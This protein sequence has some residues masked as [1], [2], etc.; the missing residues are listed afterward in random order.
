MARVRAPSSACSSRSST[1]SSTATA[2]CSTSATTGA[3]GSPTRRPSARTTRL[4]AIDAD[5]SR[6][7]RD[8]RRARFADGLMKLQ[9]RLGALAERN[10]RLV[11]SSTTISALGDGV[12]TI[13][14]AFA[15]LE[16]T[17]SATALGLV[18]AARQAS[19]AAITVAAGVWADRLP[20]HLV[21]V[22]AALVQGVGAGGR[23][24]APRDRAREVWMLVVAG[25]RL[26]ARRRVRHPDVAGADPGRSSAR[27]RL[28][29]GECAARAQPVDARRP[30]ARRVGGV[31]VACGQPGLLRC[32]STRRASA[33]AAL[34]LLRV[35][36]PQPRRQRR[37]R[38]VPRRVARRAGTSSG[39]RRWIWTTIVFFGIGNCA[40]TSRVRARPAG[41]EGALLR[42]VDLGDRWSAAF[43][44]GTILGGVVALRVST[45]AAAARLV[46]RRGAARAP[47]ARH[48]RCELPVAVLDRDRASSPGS[49]SRSIS[50]SGSPSSSST[51]PRNRALARQ[52]LRRAR[53][54]R[55]DAAR[56]R[57]RRADRGA[58]R[59]HRN[60]DRD[61]RDRGRL[62][63]RDHRAAERV[64]DRTRARRQVAVPA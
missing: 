34:L 14:L 26:R 25:A 20:R 13:A 51:S 19:A 21:L 22:A 4:A 39:G 59:R 30:R 56:L 60:A 48:A 11:F 63:S 35:S 64:G 50:R 62:P 23:R 31:L 37:A 8:R 46:P 9:G 29:A 16:I 43:G 33:P 12:T 52:L 58:D 49:G 7:R 42:R 44:A 5:T 15:V 55:A 17:D 38:A 54:V 40:S 2:S 18:I 61:L 1:T 36:I 6:A 41:R 57:D 47:A 24:D 28:A 27:V 53:L 10:F 3:A 45:V 32:S